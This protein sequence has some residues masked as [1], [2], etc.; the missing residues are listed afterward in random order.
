MSTHAPGERAAAGCRLF[1]V[2]NNHVEGSG[3]PPIIDGDQPGF[4]FGYF[5][6][7]HGEQAIYVYDHETGEATL[8]MG[9]VGWSDV[10]HVVDGEVED[11]LLTT[12]E[13]AW[14]LA[15][16]MATG[17]LKERL[18]TGT[19]GSEPGPADG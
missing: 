5:A 19:E 4:Y 18:Q 7:E 11:L 2:S 1:S 8:R 3:D 9:D 10:H 13:R 6:N 17:G 12:A 16:W 14:L 15:C